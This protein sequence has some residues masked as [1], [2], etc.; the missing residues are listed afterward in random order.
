MVVAKPPSLRDNGARQVCHSTECGVVVIGNNQIGRDS[1]PGKR[2]D[3][4]TAQ[5]AER[6]GE[7]YNKRGFDVFHD[8]GNRDNSGRIDSFISHARG[9]QLSYVDILVT[10]ENSTRVVALI[11]IE[12]TGD[13]PKKFL[14]DVFGVLLGDG[15]EYKGNSLE[16][17]EKTILIVAG[18]GNPKHNDRNEHIRDRVNRFKVNLDTGNARMGKVL[19]RTLENEQELYNFLRSELDQWVGG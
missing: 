2:D 6:L 8:H 17:D 7:E 10:S 12:E 5:I 9:R 14:G 1:M 13:E 15:M 19:V 16:L 11:E 4:I 18:I 3:Q